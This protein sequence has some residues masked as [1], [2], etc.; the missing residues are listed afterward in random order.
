M[1]DNELFLQDLLDN[2]IETLIAFYATCFQS[3][4]KAIAYAQE[5]LGLT[6][7]QAAEQAI[8]FSDRTLGKHI[9][10]KRTKIGKQIREK[11][12]ELGVYKANGREAIRGYVTVPIRDESDPSENAIGIRAYKVDAHAA[13]KDVI[14][15][16]H[17]AACAQPEIEAAKEQ[18][19]ASENIEPTQQSKSTAK[20]I[21]SDEHELITD[22]SSILFTRDDRSYR[23][24]G[25]EKNKST[26]TL[27][28]SLMVSRASLV[29]LDS[30]DLVK[31]RS[32]ASFVKAAATELYVDADTIKKDIGI[33]LLKLE[34]LQAERIAEL[35]RPAQSEVKMTEG[36]KA[37]ALELL[38]DPNLLERIV[39]DM[40]ACGIVGESTNKLA[41]YLA[42][43]SRKLDKPLAVVIQSSSS[44][45]KTSL[46]DAVLD[47]MPSEEQLRVSKLTGKSLYYLDTADIQ[48]KTLAISEDEGI[49]EA[50]YALKLLQSEG[51]LRHAAVAK[52]EAGVM[53]T[54][55]HVVHG[56]TQIFLTTTALD[57][58]EELMN[59]CLVL[60]V[61][62]S[63][64]Q[65]G[66]IQTL[67]RSARTVAAKTNRDH[68]HRIR[69]IHHNAQRMLR[70]IEVNN[71]Y[72]P[73]LTF[74]DDKTRLRRDHEKYLTLIDTIA[75]LHQHQR[76]VKTYQHHGE[77]IEYIDVQPSDIAI[78]NGMA[79]EIL[80]RSLDEL[81]PQTRNLLMKVHHYVGEL[82]TSHGIPDNAVRFTRRDLRESIGWSD[83]QIH[84]H[85]SRLVDLE[86]LI[87]HRG[88][89]GR[90]FVY[91]LLYDG[92]GRE[93]QP[94]LA[95]LIDPAKLKQPAPMTESLST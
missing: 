41:G 3:A 7:E 44:A 77:A 36:E 8:G 90:R 95:G 92:Q 17:A 28:V 19:P 75:L 73:Q 45:G 21:S 79:G 15:I 48:H 9:P 82:S 47:M 71:P 42:A 39:A 86:Y 83:F 10:S 32:R 30:L 49:R 18:R 38:K 76:Q 37:D 1:T 27:K 16:G 52:G 51:C 20:T 50:A 35:K 94:F 23:V 5:D 2:T 54:K 6:L 29:H 40:D 67:Q 13:G 70:P 84:T 64:N 89:Q 43:T 11:L 78:A 85:L 66:A 62:E 14:V 61:D 56:P 91:E 69:T 58:D 25:L 34:S 4:P 33:L 12:I 46:M 26:C 93:G 60:T 80:G 24:R 65:T 68:V 55:H 53:T 22:E 63:R 57:L 59:R 87:V 72:A 31:A 88:K 81:A 74:A